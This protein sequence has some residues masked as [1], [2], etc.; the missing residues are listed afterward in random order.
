[1]TYQEMD[2]R[3]RA[4]E[5]EEYEHKYYHTEPCYDDW[6]TEEYRIGGETEQVYVMNWERS[7]TF[8]YKKSGGV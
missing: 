3:L 6:E 4:L 7:D 5:P 1:M 2:R 8:F